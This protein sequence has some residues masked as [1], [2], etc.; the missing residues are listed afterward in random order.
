MLIQEKLLQLFQK[1][2][3]YEFESAY[4]YL[5]MAA[6]FETTPYKGFAAWMRKQ[7]KEEIDHGMRFFDYLC[8]R[9]HR[10][11]LPMIPEV[12]TYY[13]SPLS[14]FLRAL[15]HEQLVTSRI[16][17]LYRVAGEVRDYAAQIALEWFI[18]EQVEEEKQVQDLVDQIQ[19][20][21]DNVSGLMAIDR[22]ASKRD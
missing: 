5:G 8:D 20:A 16:N 9:G 15:E 12:S 13:D 10:I 21:G 22:S 14:A 18:S 7:A 4:I 3:N 1:Q 19:L 17:E 2:I 11:E 6:Y